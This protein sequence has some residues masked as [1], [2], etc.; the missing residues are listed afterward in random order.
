MRHCFR[1]LKNCQALIGWGASAEDLSGPFMLRFAGRMR[2]AREETRFFIAENPQV[3]PAGPE[4][5][6]GAR[7]K[8]FTET[9]DEPEWVAGAFCYYDGSAFPD[10]SRASA[11]TFSLTEKI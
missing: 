5:P 3:Q 10:Y 11:F 9:G 7:T 8:R 1:R 4:Q 6:E 2:E